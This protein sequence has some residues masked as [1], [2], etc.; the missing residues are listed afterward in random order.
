MLRRILNRRY[1]RSIYLPRQ[2]LQLP[3]FQ[4][5]MCARTQWVAVLTWMC[6]VVDTRMSVCM[7]E[8]IHKA[9]RR[10][11]SFCN[12][13]YVIRIYSALPHIHPRHVFINF[14]EANIWAKE[15]KEVAQSSNWK[16][17]EKWKISRQNNNISVFVQSATVLTHYHPI[18]LV[19]RVLLIRFFVSSSVHFSLFLGSKGRRKTKEK[20]SARKFSFQFAAIV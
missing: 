17:N 19:E 13:N 18:Q 6:C 4:A 9:F 10:S 7:C 5:Y 14:R 3:G 11:S 20:K 12:R 8:V 2:S 1:I 15:S 16:R